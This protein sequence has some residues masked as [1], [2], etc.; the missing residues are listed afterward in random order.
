M[1]RNVSMIRIAA[2]IA[3]ALVLTLP[4]LAQD[5]YR[6]GPEDVI[7]IRYWQ[8]PELST[9]VR[10]G[11]DGMITLDIVGQIEAAGKTVEELQSEISR[12]MSRLRKDVSQAVVRVQ[13]YNSRYVFILG[14]VADPGRKSFEEI[15][16]LWEIILRAGG[17]SAVGDLSRVTIIRGG[18]DAGKLEVVNVARAIAEDKLDQLPEIRSGDTIEIPRTPGGLPS[19]ELAQQVDR[20]N[21]IYIVGAVNAPGRQQYEENTDL[22]EVVAMAGG[23]AEDADLKRVRVISKDG[24]YGQTVEYNLE[25]YSKK[26]NLSR[27]IVRKED[28]FIIPR[29]GDGFWGGLERVATVLG[30]ASSAVL[31][32]QIFSDD[33]R[34]R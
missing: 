13:E 12:Q 6:I 20:R 27:Y 14:A 34:V 9:T 30:V 10:V 3:L 16:D 19:G 17:I 23:F 28:T 33:D 5:S 21:E 22:L 29:K 8:A 7:E 1:E 31:I 32:Y 18:D 11:L 25:E 2:L 15:P 4:V 26:G 24:N